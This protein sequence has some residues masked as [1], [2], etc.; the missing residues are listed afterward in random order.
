M[1]TPARLVDDFNDVDSASDGPEEVH[2]AS[3][4][5]MPK[6]MWKWDRVRRV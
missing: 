2:N 6:M 3:S 4:L 5:E 1:P